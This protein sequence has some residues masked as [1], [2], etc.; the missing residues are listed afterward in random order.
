[1]S[2]VHIVIL[3]RLFLCCFRDI[4]SLVR[5]TNEYFDSFM[6]IIITFST[7]GLI[8]S[9]IILLFLPNMNGKLK[10]FV[11][12]LVGLI[13]APYFYYRFVNRVAK[14]YDTGTGIR[15]DFILNIYTYVTN[16]LH[17]FFFGSSNM[18][19]KE[20]YIDYVMP[21][22]DAGLITYLVHTNGPIFTVFI[23]VFLLLRC[24]PIDRYSS[25]PFIILLLGKVPLFSP[26]APALIYMIFYRDKIKKQ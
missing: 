19:S 11:V 14:G 8:F 24:R 20:Y 17:G 2:Q 21:E 12:G 25:G 10:I 23:I 16:N 4:I 18:M 26:F 15:E 13:T 5:H 22:N 6:S 3:L 9:L 1:M 7:F